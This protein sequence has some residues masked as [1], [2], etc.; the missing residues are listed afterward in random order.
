MNLDKK[1]KRQSGRQAKQ[2]Q[3]TYQVWIDDQCKVHAKLIKPRKKIKELSETPSYIDCNTLAEQQ[4]D[5]M[6]HFQYI[7]PA[8]GNRK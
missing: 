1:R 6:S 3:V 8:K 4:L 2:V 7:A 5:N